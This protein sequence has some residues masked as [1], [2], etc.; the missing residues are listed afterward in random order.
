MKIEVSAIIKQEIDI[1]EK[2]AF[3]L[4]CKTLYM[5]FILEDRD[6]YVFEEDNCVYECRSGGDC[7]IDERGDLY[8][9]LMTIA[10]FWF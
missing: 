8:I 4:L 7:I 10:K 6:L 1:D 9:G 3:R 5:D 2:E